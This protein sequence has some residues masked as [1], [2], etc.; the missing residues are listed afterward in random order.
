[1][2]MESRN[3]PSETLDEIRSLMERSSRFISLSGLSGVAAG[4]FAIIGAVIW[5]IVK[6]F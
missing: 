5:D 2:V 3:N 6:L 1:M 4:L